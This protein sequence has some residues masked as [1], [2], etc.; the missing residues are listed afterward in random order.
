MINSYAPDACC[1]RLISIML[2]SGALDE[3][4][5]WECPKCGMEW[6]PIET[7]SD[8]PTQTPIAGSLFVNLEYPVVIRHWQPHPYQAFVPVRG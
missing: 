6:R 1:G 8:K 4:T 7:R 3:A 2:R 5:R